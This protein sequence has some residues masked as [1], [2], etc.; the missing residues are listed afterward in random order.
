M[1]LRNVFSRI[2][3]AAK[4]YSG[5]SGATIALFIAILFVFN[6]AFYALATRY[7]WYAYTRASYE[8]EIGD[9]SYSYL[10]ELDTAGRE[11]KIRFCRAPDQIDADVA[12]RLAHE[13]AKQLAA[14]HEFIT[15][16]YINIYTEPGK[17]EKYLYEYDESGERVETENRITTESII[18]DSGDEYMV[19][20][21]S[22]FYHLTEEGSVLAYNGEEVMLSM[23][24]WVLSGE[25]ETVYFTANHG[26]SSGAGFYNLLVCAGYRVQEINLTLEEIPSDAAMI[27]I[28]N[29]KYDF[30]KA[31]AG[32]GI[33]A[34]IDKLQR[35]LADG[36]RLFVSLDA[37]LGDLPH[38]DALLSSF[39]LVREHATVRDVSEAVSSDG[40]ALLTRFASGET[41]SAIA[42]SI[43]R[44]SDGRVVLREASPIEISEPANGAR[45]EALLVSAP[46][47]AAYA[48]GEQVSSSGSY[49]LAALSVNAAGGSIFLSASIYLTAE[50]LLRSDAYA[51]GEFLYALLS[52]MLGTDVPL[53]CTT[54]SFDNERIEGMTMGVVHA[55][56]IILVAAVPIAVLCV[57]NVIRVRR[58]NR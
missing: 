17:V 4:S 47:S 55:W 56:S 58:K 13:T 42:S 46:G 16:E 6:A 57:G 26:E 24:R 12:G 52:R 30:E 49:P 33:V 10:G 11:V 53:G 35:Y 15:L 41:A 37:L 50:D 29:P 51:N 21:L 23:I 34:E 40:L 48:N 5:I 45:V 14:R 43:D 38:L 31:A 44:Y 3:R 9:V 1:N 20:S 8:H 19:Q 18:F 39:G 27:V 2:G 32:S 22:S 25:H 36:G 7:S 54:L 28:S